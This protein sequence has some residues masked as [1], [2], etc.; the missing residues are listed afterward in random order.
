MLDDDKRELGKVSQKEPAAF[1]R[2]KQRAMDLGM[3]SEEFILRS[4]TA[5]IKQQEVTEVSELKD[6]IK[7]LREEIKQIRLQPQIQAQPTP[8]PQPPDM[9]KQ[10]ES[11][12]TFITTIKGMFPQTSVTDVVK[13]ITALRTAQDAIFQDSGGEDS[14]SPAD[15]ALKI[16]ADKIIPNLKMQATP[17]VAQP[18]AGPG[19][20]APPFDWQADQ[21][22][23]PSIVPNNLTNEVVNLNNEQIQQQVK[24]MPDFVKAGIK[25]GQI[26]L[27]QAKEMVISE[28]Q[29]RG[30]P[31][32]EEDIEKLYNAVK[33][34][35]P[36]PK[37][38]QKKPK[39]DVKK[40]NEGPEK[41]A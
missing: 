11:M 18:T 36:D 32:V 41:Q 23:P 2:I 6:S 14:E 1:G 16:L 34:E 37:P 4:D 10:M 31:V 29:K 38:A 35:E 28:A 39:K 22:K 26:T 40:N 25:S 17:G 7:E 3:S 24:E 27:D 15:Y 19:P 12:A 13:E 21:T 5:T 30:L 9:F 33:N 8:T 20:P